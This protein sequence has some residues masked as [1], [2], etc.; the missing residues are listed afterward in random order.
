MSINSK[1][2]RPGQANYSVTGR[3][4]YIIAKALAYAIVSIEGLPEKRREWSDAQDMKLLLALG[5]PR[6]KADLLEQAK[7]HI[8]GEGHPSAGKV[9]GHISYF[10]DV[11][12]LGA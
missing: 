8:T 7:T 5:F 1:A 9:V 10:G 12:D 6:L 3:D 2:R 11:V 4:G